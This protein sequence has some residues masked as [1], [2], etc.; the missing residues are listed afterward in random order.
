MAYTF[1]EL[2]GKTVSEL[3][4]IASGLEHEAVQ[5]YTQM[6]KERLLAALCR[7]LGIEMR[8]KHQVVGVDKTAIKAQ[9]RRLRAQ[10]D[11]AM[12]AKDRASLKSYRTGIRKLKRRLRKAMV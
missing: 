2:E 4:E 8:E 3:R 5:G 11:A 7:A 12:A 6:N 1:K 9:I 10:R